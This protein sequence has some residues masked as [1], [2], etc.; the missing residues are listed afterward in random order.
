[1]G[2]NKLCLL[3]DLPSDHGVVRD[4]LVRKEWTEVSKKV[5]KR[6]FINE[7]ECLTGSLMS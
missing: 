2:L 5:S 3:K 7:T 4:V 1:M 6:T